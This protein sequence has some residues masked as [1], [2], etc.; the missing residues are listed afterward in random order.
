M[1]YMNKA[2]VIFSPGDKVKLTKKALVAAVNPE[3]AL[4][5]GQPIKD[6]V[7]VSLFPDVKG[8]VLLRQKL[9]GYWTWDVDDLEKV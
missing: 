6:S 8:L 4:F 5:A 1:K 9:G 3:P 7:V 2:K